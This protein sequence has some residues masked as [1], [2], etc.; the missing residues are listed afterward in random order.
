MSRS[1][2]EARSD[3]RR[4]HN[5]LPILLAVL[6]AWI[7]TGIDV[8]GQRRNGQVPSVAS[9]TVESAHG[10]TGHAP[11]GLFMADASEQ[12]VRSYHPAF[13]ASESAGTLG[14]WMLTSLC[15]LLLGAAVAPV[16]V[17]RLRQ[18]LGSADSQA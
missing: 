6:L 5:L 1:S 4:T 17:Q 3:S 15:A 12:Q 7:S 2:A 9:A 18:R 10:T 13:Q 8:A 16:A 11:R 14:F